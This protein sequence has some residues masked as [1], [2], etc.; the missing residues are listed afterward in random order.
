MKTYLIYIPASNDEGYSIIEITTE[1]INIYGDRVEF[2]SNK[3]GTSATFYLSK[4]IGYTKV[5]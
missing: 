2:Y 4:I 5:K 1:S 3:E